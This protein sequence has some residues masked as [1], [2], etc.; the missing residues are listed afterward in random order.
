MSCLILR[1]GEEDMN[2]GTAKVIAIVI[3]LV[4]V[5]SAF[6]GLVSIFG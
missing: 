1:K 2:R 6:A 3:A 4:M 5:I